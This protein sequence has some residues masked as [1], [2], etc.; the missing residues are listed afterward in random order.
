MSAT[1][2]RPKWL[3]VREVCEETGSHKDTVLGWLRRGELR[4]SKRGPGR[5]AHWR[6]RPEHLD[7]FFRARVNKRVS[8][9]S[10]TGGER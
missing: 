3:T 6:V 7:A 10:E 8:I 2:T 1:A 4:G 5:N 9:L